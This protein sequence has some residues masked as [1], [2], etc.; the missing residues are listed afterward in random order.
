[1][2]KSVAADLAA[3]AS[4]SGNA[5]VMGADKSDANEAGGG[6]VFVFEKINGI[7]VQTAR[8]RLRAMRC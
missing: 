6:A 8:N 2:L 7:W 1:M 4:I 5:V 3:C